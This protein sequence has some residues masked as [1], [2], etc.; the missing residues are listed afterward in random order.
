M[1]AELQQH[2]ER[3]LEV[4]LP[5]RKLSLKL[6]ELSLSASCTSE[7]P[8]LLLYLSCLLIQLRPEHMQSRLDAGALSFLH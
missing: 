1:Q 8:A 5:T 2:W 7:L 4:L 6:G 3:H